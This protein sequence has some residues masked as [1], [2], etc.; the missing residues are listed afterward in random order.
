MYV[1]YAWFAKDGG[2]GNLVSFWTN[3]F[4]SFKLGRTLSF[5]S[6]NISPI[7]SGLSTF[8]GA[9]FGCFPGKTNELLSNLSKFC[10]ELNNFWLYF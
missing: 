7:L 6:F 9:V 10:K 3:S 4:S 1:I 8:L 2:I 5:T